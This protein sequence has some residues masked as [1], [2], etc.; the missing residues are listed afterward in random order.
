M[1]WMDKLKGTIKVNKKTLLFFTILLIIGIIAG[2]IFM[3]ILSETDKKL[4][5]DYFNN[6]ISNIENNKLNYLEGIKNGL[7]NNLIYIIII[8]ILGISIIGIPIVTI[9]FFIKSF[10]LGFSIASIV[11]NYKLKGCLLNFINIFPHQMI[12]FLIYMLITTYSIFFSLKMINS[13]INKK[14]MDFKIM[15]NKYVKIL[16]IS[17]IAITIGIIIETF[18]TPLLIKIIIPLIK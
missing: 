8:W 18:I 16:I 15:M 4:V 3:A 7:F 17:V 12:Y 2:S 10:T 14:N 11:F 1:K 13:I 9:M 5:T 6:Y